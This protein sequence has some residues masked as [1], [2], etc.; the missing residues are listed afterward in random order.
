MI[1]FS[2]AS[3]KGSPPE[4]EGEFSKT[5]FYSTSN[6]MHGVVNLTAGITKQTKITCVGMQNEIWGLFLHVSDY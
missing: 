2:R 1:S 5:E 4:I 3:T 6:A